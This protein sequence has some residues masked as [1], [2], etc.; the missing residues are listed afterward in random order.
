MTR[1]LILV[2]FVLTTAC[3]K[4]DPPPTADRG[5]G[6]ASAVTV[7]PADAAP[8]PSEA[9]KVA[10]AVKKA[11]DEAA[12][13]ATRWTADLKAKAIALRDGKY[14][15]AK[16]ALTALLASEHRMPGHKDRDPARHPVET[17]TFF[18][19]TPTMTVVELGA[20]GGWYTELLAPLLAN[21]GKLVVAGP[22]AAGPTD[23]MSSVYGKRLDMFLAKS[24]DLFGKV[25]R[26]SIKPDAIKLGADGS[27]DLVLA[28]REMHN[29]QRRG[30][31]DKY[32]TAIHAALKDG[33]TF[34]LVA[35]RAKDGT[36]GE[37]TAESG[38]L[39]EKWVIEKVT[40]KGFEL[41]EKSEINA[42]PKDTKDYAKGVWTLP[43]NF[44]L[45]DTDKAK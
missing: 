13:E 18:G 40:A 32:L 30:E 17:L 3:K 27:A 41:V 9:E 5:S 39:E 2:A 38:Y 25:E 26:V 12:K 42:N 24:P 31:L 21:K 15:D 6:S 10:A 37:A 28:I 23:K 43:P 4:T 1:C 19:L 36:K 11:E 34:G 29:W 7:A 20:G 16:E 33:G 8:A 35:H 45:E 44:A 14:K 22:D